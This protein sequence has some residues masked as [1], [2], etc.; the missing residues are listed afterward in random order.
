MN[1]S[2]RVKQFFLSTAPRSSVGMLQ[3][4]VLR[5]LD[6]QKEPL[7][8]NSVVMSLINWAWVQSSAAPLA[9]F[10]KD[11][12]TDQDEIVKLPLVLEAITAPVQ[13]ISSRNAMFG[14]WMSLITEGTAFF[15][16]VRDTR[17]RV[18]GLQYLYHYYC[19]FQGGKVQYVAPSG[20]TT[21]FDEQDLI[22]LRYGIDPEDSRRGYSPL[23]ACL[24]EVLTD[25]EASE[26]LRAVLS[27]FG[28]VG[29]IISSDDASANFDEDAVKAI[30]AAWKSATTGSNRGKTL[31]SSTKL[32][33]QEIR[34]N[35][36]DMILEKVRNIPEQRI[37]AAF[38]VPPAVLQLASGQETSTYNNLTQMIRLAWNQFLIPVTDIIA[39]QFTDQFLRIFTDD[40]ALYLGYDR[41]GVEALQLDRA[42]LEARYTLLYQGGIVMLNEARTALDFEPA[43]VDGFYQDLSSAASLTLAKA[44]LAESLAK[45]QGRSDV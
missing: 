37:C 23:K 45:K 15:Y 27:N 44:R 7:H 36:K 20:E 8:L 14:M 19:T 34:S 42:E 10:K 6:P 25:Q 3:V 29:S 32:K 13:G 41:R 31:V 5:S 17:G 1:L 16:P 26:Y 35:P 22:I 43:S 2:Q 33:I 38:G 40:S 18:V 21:Y 39:S 12:A 30:T 24:R 28:V 11:D 9:V 4:P